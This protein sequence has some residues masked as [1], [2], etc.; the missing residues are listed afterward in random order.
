VP[1]Y[2]LGPRHGHAAG[3]KRL[4]AAVAREVD[5]L[6]GLH[7]PSRRIPTIRDVLDVLHLRRR[8][9]PT[10]AKLM[11]MDRSEFRAFVRTTGLEGR[12]TRALS[13][14]DHDAP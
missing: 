10:A 13:D 4:L 1:Y 12:I 3:R 2:G 6:S 5:E 7:T 9:R 8:R 11:Q 14:S